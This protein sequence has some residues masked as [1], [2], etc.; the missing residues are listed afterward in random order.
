MIVPLPENITAPCEQCK[1]YY[2]GYTE[3]DKIH[4]KCFDELDKISK[5]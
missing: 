5:I 1:L 3:A 4:R 2:K